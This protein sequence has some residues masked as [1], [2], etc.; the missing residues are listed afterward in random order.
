MDF[1][2]GDSAFQEKRFSE[3]EVLNF[4]KLTQ[5]D[6]P[7]HLDKRYAGKSRFGK[8]IV[9]GPMVA[10]LL[11]GVLGSKLPGPGTIYIKQET[12]FLKPV[13][14]DQLLKANV[15]VIK[16]K[17]NKPIITLR[18]WVEDEE[19]ETVIDGAAVIYYLGESMTS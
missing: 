16:I 6:N 12:S 2:I 18:T 4:S 11:G 19:G 15:E 17:E 14:I 3:Q 10:S 8:R 13:F 9:Q 1:K 7:I 5:D